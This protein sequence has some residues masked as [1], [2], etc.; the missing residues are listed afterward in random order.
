[1]EIPDALIQLAE[2]EDA[3]D[4][5]AS[6][7]E[8]VDDF[9]ARWELDLGKPFTDGNVSLAIP[10][11]RKAEHVVLKLQ[12]PH[13]ECE[14]EADA[15]RLWDGSGAVRLLEHDRENY[16]LLLERCVPGTHLSKDKQTDK[17]GVVI[18]L[19]R[20][21]W[22]PTSG[23]FNTLANE[24]NGWCKRLEKN[25]LA[26]GK[27]CEKS[28]IDITM[29][30]INNLNL[31]QG[32]QVLIHQDLHGE[33]ILSS[34]RDTWL[35]IDPKPLIGEREFGLSPVIRSYEFGDQKKNA[36]YRLDRLTEELELDRERASGW[37]MAQSIAW[38]FGSPFPERHY[39]T[40]RWLLE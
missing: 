29:E 36:L 12:W 26:A 23:P 33:N 25:W 20:K 30:T 32:E 13:S 21:L 19:L 39:E 5:L 6:L 18:D 1:M 28:L 37:A 38:S 40:A 31:S 27:P 14:F 15:L 11:T 3:G 10:A 4:W 22:V 9:R 34:E 35:A 17:L 8:L 24:S 16:A 2:H 7:P